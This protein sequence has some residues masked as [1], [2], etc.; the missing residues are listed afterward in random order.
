VEASDA[1]HAVKER[2]FSA[3]FSHRKTLASALSF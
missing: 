3:V 2:R 1:G